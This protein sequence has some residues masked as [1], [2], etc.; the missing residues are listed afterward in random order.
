MS[1]SS[2]APAERVFTKVDSSRGHMM[3]ACLI[4]HWRL[5]F[6]ALVTRFEVRV[7]YN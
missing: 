3:L 7:T 5:Q 6:V 4:P 2:F 1:L